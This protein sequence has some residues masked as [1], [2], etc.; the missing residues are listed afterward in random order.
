MKMIE[1]KTRKMLR[2]IFGGISLTAMAFVF[3]ACYGMPNDYSDYVRFI[4]TVKS[5]TTLLPIEGIKVIVNNDGYNFG[6]T[7]EDGKFDFYS[8]V[9]N[10]TFSKN[11]KNA[12]E[13]ISVQFSDI[14]GAQ[15]GNFA[16]T[17]V[18]VIPDRLNTIVIYLEMREIQ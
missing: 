3:Q 10:Q 18:I 7:N 17:T 2:K 14:D 1:L 4:G 13:E 9:P 15:N 6:I 5:N 16:D 12:S 11:R 8:T